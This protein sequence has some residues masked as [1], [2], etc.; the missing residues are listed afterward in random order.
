[1]DAWA[2]YLRGQADALALP[3]LD[4]TNRSI[5]EV[6]D[7]LREYIDRLRGSAGAAA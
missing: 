3:V 7:L 5:A 1:M 2:A 4:S 6:A